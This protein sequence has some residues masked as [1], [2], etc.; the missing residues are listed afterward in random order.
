MAI[1]NGIDLTRYEHRQPTGNLRRELGLTPDVSLFGFLG[2]FMPQKGFLILIEALAALARRP[3]ARRFHLLATG[4]GDF[5]REYKAEVARRGELNGRVTFQEHV[6]DVAPI[7]REL[8]LLVI[9][10]LWEACPIL[11]MEALV[12]GVPVLGSDC[13]G[14]REVLRGSAAQGWSA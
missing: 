6:P 3:N 5:V 12:S 11:P 4:S 1:P 2:R 7:L 14:L 13:I 8:D 10:S 9:P